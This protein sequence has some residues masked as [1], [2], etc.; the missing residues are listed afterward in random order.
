MIPFYADPA[1]RLFLSDAFEFLDQVE[2]GLIDVT[3]ADIPYAKSTADGA[4]G[5]TEDGP[6]RIVDFGNFTEA[7]TIHAVYAMARVTR[8]WLLVCMDHE[9]VHVVRKLPPRGWQFVRHGCWWKSGAAPQ[10]SGDRPGQGWESLVVLHPLGRM[11]WNG[12]GHP[13][14]WEE[15]IARAGLAED[16]EQNSTEK[17]VPLVR[18]LLEQFADPGDYVLDPFCGRGATLV[19]AKDL[20]LKAIGVD[21]RVGQ[22]RATQRRLRQ[23]VLPLPRPVIERVQL[24]LEGS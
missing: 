9:H 14:L 7:D 4:R 1:S 15:Q 6:K 18:K 10:F 16:G 2:P 12:G 23:S 8:R 24:K 11:H 5:L 17:P 3:F 22:L 19:A 13:A 21:K 20:G